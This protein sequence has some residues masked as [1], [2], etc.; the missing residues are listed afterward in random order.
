MI[1]RRPQKPRNTHPTKTRP[2]INTQYHL[3]CPKPRCL[4]TSTKSIKNLDNMSS[5]EPS[6]LT[7]AGPEKGKMAEGQDKNFKIAVMNMIKVPREDVNKSLTEVY[8]TTN[9]GMK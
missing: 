1:Q 2:D 8:E 9:N 6:N 5:P 4:N 7:T 3:N